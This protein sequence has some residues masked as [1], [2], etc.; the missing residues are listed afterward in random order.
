MTSGKSVECFG[1]TAT[2]M[3]GVAIALTSVNGGQAKVVDRVALFKIY[4][5]KLPAP[6]KKNKIKYVLQ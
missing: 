1:S 2:R 3:I 4:C 5:S 6:D